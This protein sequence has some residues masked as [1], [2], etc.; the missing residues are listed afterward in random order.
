MKR[1][2]VLT[3][4]MAVMLLLPALATPPSARAHMSHGMMMHGG[5][6][7]FYLMN[8]DGLGLKSDQVQK[9]QSIRMGF[10]KMAIMEKAR[11]K[12]LHFETMALMMKHH[13]DTDA[14]KANMDKILAHKKVMMRAYVMMVAKAHDVLTGDQFLKAKTLWRQHIAMMHHMMMASPH[15]D[16]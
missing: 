14:V 9:L 12:V 6:V 7:A 11:I 2:V 5:P 10:M 13:I 4:L 16:M 3:M 1:N 15:H 8:R